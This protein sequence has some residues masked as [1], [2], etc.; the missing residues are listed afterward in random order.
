MRQ[1]TYHSLHANRSSRFCRLLGRHPDHCGFCS[2]GTDVLAYSRSLWGVVA[3]V[4]PLH[5]RGGD[6][7][8]LWRDARGVADHHCQYHY[9]R[10]VGCRAGSEGD[11]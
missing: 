8:G 11:A 3:D 1:R 9:A 4:Q 2:L 7:A 5:P 10:A 6:V